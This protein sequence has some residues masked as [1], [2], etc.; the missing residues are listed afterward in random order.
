[1]H[2]P[3]QTFLRAWCRVLPGARFGHACV[4]V[5]AGMIPLAATGA[6]LASSTTGDLGRTAKAVQGPVR[7]VEVTSTQLQQEVSAKFPLRSCLM[8]LACV[9][10]SQPKVKLFEG[11]PCIY[12]SA[13]ALPQVPGSDLPAGYLEARGQPRYAPTEGAFYVEDASFTRVAFGN[14]PPTQAAIAAQVASAM[15]SEILASVPV[16]RLDEGDTRQALARMVLQSVHVRNGRL[17]LTMSGSGPD[18]APDYGEPDLDVPVAPPRGKAPADS[19]RKPS[20]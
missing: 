5:A 13:T 2:Y 11:D 1:M 6:P 9:T 17:L 14:L 4:V 15:L 8:Q 7:V 12:L 16:W 3:R 19:S 10:L 18:V 20:R